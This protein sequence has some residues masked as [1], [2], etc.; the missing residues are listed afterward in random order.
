MGTMIVAHA[1]FYCTDLGLCYNGTMKQRFET[2]WKTIHCPQCGA[3]LPLYLAQTKLV[4]CRQ[5]HSMIFLEDEAVRVAG[6]ASVLAPEPSLVTLEEP[7]AYE[8][9]SYLPLGKIRYGYGRGFWEEWW[10]QNDEGAP[11]WLSIDE[12]DFALETADATH[13]YTAEMLEGIGVGA[14]LPGGW[15]VTETG[16]GVCDGFEGSLPWEVRIGETY[17]YLQLTDETTRLRT[18]EIDTGGIRSF[19]GRWIDPFAIEVR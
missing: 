1:F 6:V 18:I 17:R 13:P 14:M 5:C 8:G 19:T 15:V 11:Y 9:V 3:V 12:G 2:P 16:T 7:F 4:Q 10:V